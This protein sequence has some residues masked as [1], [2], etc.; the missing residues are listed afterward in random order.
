MYDKDACSK[1]HAQNTDSATAKSQAIFVVARLKGLF[2]LHGIAQ[3]RLQIE[4]G[5]YMRCELYRGAKLRSLVSS[6]KKS[7]QSVYIAHDFESIE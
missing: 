5:K 4:T 6:L 3:Q 2:I 1:L 7:R